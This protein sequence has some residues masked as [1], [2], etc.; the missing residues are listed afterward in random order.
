[1][2]RTKNC[3]TLVV[4]R[5]E[6]AQFTKTESSVFKLSMLSSLGTMR[7]KIIVKIN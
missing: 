7:D 5:T 6:H 4:C 1:M 2:H 3:V